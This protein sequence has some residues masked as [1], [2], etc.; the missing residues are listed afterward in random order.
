MFATLK[1]NQESIEGNGRFVQNAIQRQQITARTLV[2]IVTNTRVHLQILII[3]VSP[4]IHTSVQNVTAA[5]E[6]SKRIF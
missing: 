6:T 5:T 3:A 4:A 1:L 2:L